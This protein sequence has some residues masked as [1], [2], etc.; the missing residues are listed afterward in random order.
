MHFYF[1]G[2]IY[3]PY[4]VFTNTSEGPGSSMGAVCN[5]TASLKLVDNL[6]IINLWNVLGRSLAAILVDWRYKIQGKCFYSIMLKI[7]KKKTI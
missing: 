1:V 3:K 5:S 6:V 7:F 2:Q 4:L